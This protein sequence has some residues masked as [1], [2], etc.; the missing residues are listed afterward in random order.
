[1]GAGAAPEGDQGGA[2]GFEDFAG[3]S[4]EL[5]NGVSGGWDDASDGGGWGD[6][7]IGGGER[8]SG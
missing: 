3:G 2:G 4:E 7:L 1:V 8:L 5:G 6:F